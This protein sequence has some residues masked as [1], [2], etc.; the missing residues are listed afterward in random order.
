MNLV[1]CCTPIDREASFERDLRF[2]LLASLFFRRAYPEA[3]VYVGT[4]LDA[5]VPE[6]F[7][8]FFTVAR[9]DFAANPFAISRQLFYA[10]FCRGSHFTDDTVFAGMDV[11]W[12]NKPFPELEDHKMMVSY[13][14]HPSQPYCSDLIVVRKDHGDFAATFFDN[15]VKM[16]VFLPKGVLSFWADQIA[17]S[18]GIGKLGENDFDGQIHRAPRYR[19]ILLVPGDDY[20]YTPN[21]I[22]SSVRTSF[23]TAIRTGK[24][25]TTTEQML[26]LMYSKHGIHFKGARKPWFFL[27]AL[28]VYEKGWINPYAHGDHIPLKQLFDEAFV[29]DEKEA[30]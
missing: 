2:P 28:L 3:K 19:D 11:L 17:M 22:F 29:K 14:F 24:D 9:F 6:H 30:A 10:S 16:M 5:K 15:I 25:V 21:D 12:G 20:L 27:L 26:K 18:I 1:M 7:K 8:Q 4:T 23:V 13:R